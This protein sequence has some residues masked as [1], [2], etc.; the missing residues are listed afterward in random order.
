D[1]LAAVDF[2]N[3]LNEALGLSLPATSV[4]DHPTP[5]EFAAYL[6]PM[7]GEDEL[8]EG[9][10]LAE[11]DKLESKLATM[12]A[13]AGTPD[14]AARLE[15]LPARW[16]VGKGETADAEAVGNLQSA[17]RDEVFDFIDNELGI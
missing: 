10:V 17:T 9:A 6:R 7:L 12:A 2:R 13:G 3:R 16:G 4:F 15:A 11:I 5:R 14:I 8:S 1:S